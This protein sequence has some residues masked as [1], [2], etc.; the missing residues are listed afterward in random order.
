MLRDILNHGDEG[1]LSS[2]IYFQF[3]LAGVL[4]MQRR[5]SEAEATFQHVLNGDGVLTDQT[6]VSFTQGLGRALRRQKKFAEAEV[7]ARQ[8]SENMLIHGHADLK[9]QIAL[10]AVGKVKLT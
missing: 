3:V 6:R 5:S 10:L 9:L 2:R 8:A 4:M 1:E 7:V